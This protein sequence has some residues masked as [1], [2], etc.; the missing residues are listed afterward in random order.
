MGEVIQSSTG[1]IIDDMDAKAFLQQQIHHVTADEARAAGD[2]SDSF[3]THFRPIFLTV[4]TLKYRSSPRLLGNL[5][6]LNA[7]HRSRTASSTLRFGTKPNLAAIF[8]EETWYERRSLDGVVSTRIGAF[9]G[10]SSSTIL[11]TISAI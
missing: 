5:P 3:R 4:L 10:N 7:R 9:S 11:R 1:Q 6:A 2:D 8:F